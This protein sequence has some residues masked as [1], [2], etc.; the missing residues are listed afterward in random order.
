[1][2]GRARRRGQPLSAPFPVPHAA[3]V[4]IPRRGRPVPQLRR[5][6]RRVRARRGPSWSSR[7]PAPSPT[8]TPCTP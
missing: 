1:V 8:A 5:G 2:R 7:W 3:A 6:G 4:R